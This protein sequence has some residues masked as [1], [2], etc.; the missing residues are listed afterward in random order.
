MINSNLLL[1]LLVLLICFFP[2]FF[3]HWLI[4]K[5]Y[6]ADGLKRP[7]KYKKRCEAYKKRWNC[8]QGALLIPLFSSESNIKY[9][10]LAS[11]NY[12]HFLIAT[13][14]MISFFLYEK[15]GSFLFDLRHGVFGIS[16]YALL[17]IQLF[18]LKFG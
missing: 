17:V 13:L 18:I 1:I 16:I 10:L 11:L 7:K 4:R 9:R 6:I 15:T 8:F 2:F 5:S 3:I 14:A 12:C